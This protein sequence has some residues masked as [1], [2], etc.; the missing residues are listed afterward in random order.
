MRNRSR[1]RLRTECKSECNAIRDFHARRAHSR[2]YADAREKFFERQILTA[3]NVRLTNPP[4][5]GCEEVALDVT[6][7]VMSPSVEGAGTGTPVL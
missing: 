2:R 4:A 7:L 1:Y 3:K 6:Q 5:L